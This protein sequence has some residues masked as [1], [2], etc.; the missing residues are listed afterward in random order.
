MRIVLDTNALA[1][2]LLSPNGAPAAVLQLV[3]AGRIVLCLDARILIEYRE[4]LRRPKL[5]FDT[6]LVDDL[7]QF[8]ES[9]GELVASVPLPLSLP[10]PDDAMVL[11][12]ASAGGANHVVTGNLRHF[13]IGERRG[14]SVVSPRDFLDI[15]VGER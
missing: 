3:L 7:L 8:L 1:S 4:V 9:Q 15:V 10:D 11:E 13:P 14:V 5:E 2:A 6:R 12:V